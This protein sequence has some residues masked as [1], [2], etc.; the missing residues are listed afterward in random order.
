MTDREKEQADFDRLLD[1]ERGAGLSG[2]GMGG[3]E[4]RWSDLRDGGG[5]GGAG[6]G[7]KEEIW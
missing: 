1:S 6:G 7:K 5:A 4:T 2:R 3:G